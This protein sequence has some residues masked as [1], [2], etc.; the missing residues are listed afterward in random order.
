[1]NLKEKKYLLLDLDGVYMDHTM[2]IPLK[3]FLEW[4]QK[5]G[6]DIIYPRKNLI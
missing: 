4:F 3:K 2:D 6:N 1:M 5:R